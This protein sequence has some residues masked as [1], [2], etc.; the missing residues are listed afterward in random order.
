[1]VKSDIMNGE[2]KILKINPQNKSSYKMPTTVYFGRNS[3]STLL[4]ILKQNKLS[5]TLFVVGKHTQKYKNIQSL[6]SKYGKTYP[7]EI[8]KSDFMSLNLLADFIRKNKYDSIVAIGGG[9]IIDI[10]KAANVIAENVGKAEDYLVSKNK[11]I[12]KRG[13]FLIAVPTTSGTGSEVTPWSVIWG[14]KKYSL[15]SDFMFPD[16]AIV[17]SSLTDSLPKNV[18]AESGIDAMCQSIESFWNV[19]H[20][21]VSDKYALR[22]IKIVINDLEKSVNNPDKK[23]RDNMALGSVLGGLAFSNTQTTICHSV[24]YPLTAHFGI[25]HGQ[26]TSI[27][28]PLFIEYI[29]PVLNI[30]R[31]KKLLNSIGVNSISKASEKIR[32]LMKKINLKTKLSELGIKNKDIALI[33][34]EGFDPSRAGNSPRI[35]TQE[36][37]HELLLSIL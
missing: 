27:T 3:V 16:F 35:P 24:S 19:K 14:N 7:K 28:L 26:A 21:S 10:A 37:L 13:K 18:T 17:D 4:K 23:S 8:K 2:Q 34:K 20:N 22:S 31:R 29:L 33:V 36:E 12:K 32:S 11:K 25:V 30:K 5:K 1:M 9:T 15:Q 6:I